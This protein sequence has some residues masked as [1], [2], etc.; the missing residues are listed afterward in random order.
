MDELKEQPVSDTPAQ[1][2][3]QAAKTENVHVASQP[4]NIPSVPAPSNAPVTPAAIQQPVA[5][6][7]PKP[8]STDEPK[9][10]VMAIIV[11]VIVVVVLAAVAYYAYTKSK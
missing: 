5:T 8:R 4:D 9:A 3:P 7:M 10:P 11:A 2:A 1:P 6:K